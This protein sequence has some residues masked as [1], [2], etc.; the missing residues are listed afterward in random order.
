MADGGT[1]RVIAFG[2]F[3]GTGLRARHR[4]ERDGVDRSASSSSASATS[5]SSLS[6]LSALSVAAT[7][8]EAAS[9]RDADKNGE[10]QNRSEEWG[11][12]HGT[13][14]I[15][16][17]QRTAVSRRK[18]R[19]TADHDSWATAATRPPLAT[20]AQERRR[21]S[22]QLE[23]DMMDMAHSTGPWLGSHAE[24]CIGAH[25]FPSPADWLPGC[26]LGTRI[27]LGGCL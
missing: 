24:L 5:S 6:S 1:G 15:T 19:V 2:R 25:K 18:G 3:F 11:R 27:A 21:C 9:H 23:T 14:W 10:S 17:N 13:A 8:M 26:I 4:R 20:L 22:S 12:G 7:N 16:T